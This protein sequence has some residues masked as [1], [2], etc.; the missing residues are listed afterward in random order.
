LQTLLLARHGESEANAAG[1]VNGDPS[2][3]SPLTAAGREQARRLGEALAGE[4]IDLC[5]VTPFARTADTAAIALAGRDVPTLV[6]AELADPRAGELEG[7]R[8]AE[9]RAWIESH[10]LDVA[11]AGGESHLEA[12]RRFAHGYERLLALPYAT[13]LH[14]GHSFPIS[15]ALSLAS[16][17]PP[18]GALVHFDGVD[19]ACGPIQLYT[20]IHRMERG[21]AWSS[22]STSRMP[23]AYDLPRSS[24]V[25]LE[26]ASYR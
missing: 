16:G 13:V 26:S 23:W 6:V 24:P 20:L 22:R 4:A 7:L 15:V 17:P 1:I 10:A 5:A 9:Y 12:L 3:P 8:F 14:V 18:A 19:P 25:P 21:A 11:P 2:R